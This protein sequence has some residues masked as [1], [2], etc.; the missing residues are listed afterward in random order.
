MK[1]VIVRHGDPDYVND[2]LTETGW[3][4]A[5]LAA[6]RIS[7][8]DVKAFYVSPLGRAQDTAKCTLD[9]MGRTATTYE[10]LREFAPKINRPDIEGDANHRDGICAWDWLPSDW[11][12]ESI[13]YDKDNWFNHELMKAG[14]VD[15]EYRWVCEEFDKLLEA[16]GYKRKDNYYEVLEANNDTIVIFCHFG[17][18]CVLLS[19]LVN[20]SPMQLWHGFCAAP[21]SIT[22]VRT[23]ERRE[24]IASFRISEF[25]DTSHFYVEGREPGFPARFC[26]CYKNENERH[27]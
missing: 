14:K 21:A 20:I 23:E 7:K 19:R 5:K 11:T 8:M 22:I 27:D 17:A 16:H 3:E 25:G 10:W 9:K 18:E 24:G 12:K 13:F 6:E 4:E 15:E 1:I 2:T 26:E